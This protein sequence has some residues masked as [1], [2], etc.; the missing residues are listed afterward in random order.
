MNLEDREKVREIFARYSAIDTPERHEEWLS[1]FTPDATVTSSVAPPIEGQQGLRQFT[2]MLAQSDYQAV[3]MRHILENVSMTLS[4][5]SGT[6]RGTLTVWHTV[7]GATSL[8]MVGVN[9]AKL[10]KV[11]DEWLIYELDQVVDTAIGQ[12]DLKS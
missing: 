6:A 10:R 7:G 3:Q 4:A 2:E 1:L 5:D 9:T 8:F 11:G 12:I